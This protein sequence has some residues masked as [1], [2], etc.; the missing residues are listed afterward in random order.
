MSTKLRITDLRAGYVVDFASLPG[1]EAYAFAFDTVEDAGPGQMMKELPFGNP[2][3]GSRYALV[4]DP[5][6]PGP[7]ITFEHFGEYAATDPNIEVAVLTPEEQEA[8]IKAL[9]G[10][11]DNW[12]PV[13]GW[14]VQSNKD[15]GVERHTPSAVQMQWWTE[16]GEPGYDQPERGVL[17]TNWNYVSQKVSNWLES[18]GFS[19]E[20]SDE[21]IEHDCKV[22][23]SSPDSYSW[24]PSWTMDEEGNIYTVDDH[25]GVIEALAMTDK[26]HPAHLLPDWVT[27]QEL[28]D[29]GFEKVEGDD[30]ESGFFPGQT[31][32]PEQDAEVLFGKG[33]EAVIFRRTEQSQFYG[34]WDVWVKWPERTVY[35]VS[36][37]DDSSGAV[38]WYPLREDAERRYE[39]AMIEYPDDEINLWSEEVP[40]DMDD[41]SVTQQADDA[42]WER[43]YEP[44]RWRKGKN[45]SAKPHDKPP[46]D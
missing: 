8:K 19:L 9:A 18:L 1:M 42:M 27:D 12:T 43:D 28:R 4:D 46:T 23:R 36:I 7:Y 35:C 14:S 37:E 31:D 13:D 32:T 40:D 45:H 20:W 2:L 29:E 44:I 5:M 33:A 3:T 17:L 6:D 26:E 41:E 24:T 34:K 10:R 30:R 25:D 21:W 11:L 16:Y 15:H 39:G 38:D 22:Y